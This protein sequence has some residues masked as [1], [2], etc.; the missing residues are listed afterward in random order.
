MILAK[1]A[2][3][4]CMVSTVLS[5]ADGASLNSEESSPD[6]FMLIVCVCAWHI[7]HFAIPRIFAGMVVWEVFNKGEHGWN[8]CWCSMQFGRKSSGPT[9]TKVD[10]CR[11]NCCVSIL[12]NSISYIDLRVHPKSFSDQRIFT[13]CHLLR[14]HHSCQRCFVV[15]SHTSCARAT[16]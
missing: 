11:E 14:G 1:K 10:A 13:M 7:S 2:I 6:H 15:F 4:V 3:H 12:W 8:E 16:S 9:F 5:A